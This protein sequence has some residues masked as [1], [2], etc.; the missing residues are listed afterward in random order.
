MTP[1]TA[2]VEIFY[3][4]MD[5]IIRENNAQDVETTSSEADP[6]RSYKFTIGGKEYHVGIFEKK[7]VLKMSSGDGTA[8][9]QLLA[10]LE[11][12]LDGAGIKAEDVKTERIAYESSWF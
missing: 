9:V 1:K 5:K 12:E 6:R 2:K 4:V 8:P 7:N 3:S 11:K 10:L